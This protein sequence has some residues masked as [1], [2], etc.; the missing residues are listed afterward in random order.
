MI[1]LFYVL[2]YARGQRAR[3][4]SRSFACDRVS[5]SSITVL[6]HMYF[7][8]TLLDYKNGIDSPSREPRTV[9]CVSP[10]AKS[11]C[12]PPCALFHGRSPPAIA[13]GRSRRHSARTPRDLVQNYLR[14]ATQRSKRVVIHEMARYG[15][16]RRCLRDRA[17][18]Q[19]R[20]TSYLTC[21]P[22]QNM[23]RAR[24]DTTRRVICTARHSAVGVMLFTRRRA[25]TIPIHEHCSQ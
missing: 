1:K 20:T 5:V 23:A 17:A 25:Y 21:T 13:L 16:H 14:S 24:L 22:S 11:H 10:I 2:E 6:F 9:R 19:V 3:I 8:N 7:V 12:R 4:C 15:R 18:S